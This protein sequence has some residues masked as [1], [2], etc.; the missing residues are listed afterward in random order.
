MHADLHL[1]LF[2]LQIQLQPT[3]KLRRL[4]PK[5]RIEKLFSFMLSSTLLSNLEPKLF[6]EEPFFVYNKGRAR[7]VSPGLSF[8]AEMNARAIEV[9]KRPAS[10]LAKNALR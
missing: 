9:T 8:L 5:C 3:Q 2:A 10:N 4:R 7:G 1:H 6:H